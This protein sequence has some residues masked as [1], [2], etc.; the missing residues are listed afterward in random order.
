MAA[1]Y[2]FHLEKMDMEGVQDF[3]RM[4]MEDDVF[5]RVFIADT[6]GNAVWSDGTGSNI[7]A[8]QIF[9][10]SLE[11]NEVITRGVEA[12]EK[13]NGYLVLGTPITDD[14]NRT[15]GVIGGYCD[16][17]LLAD[18]VFH[19]IYDGKGCV[20]LSAAEGEFPGR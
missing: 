17:R 20:F 2:A 11:G 1:D 6:Q 13:H 5:S 15:L 8:T 3:S 16:M 9:E 18:E 14:H 4:L 12:G 7:A 19:D 10:Q